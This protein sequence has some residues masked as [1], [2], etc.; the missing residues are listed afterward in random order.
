MPYLAIARYFSNLV[1]GPARRRVSYEFE[2]LSNIENRADKGLWPGCVPEGAVL[3]D[4]SDRST[5]VASN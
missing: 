1:T 2:G 3:V 5:I 4:W